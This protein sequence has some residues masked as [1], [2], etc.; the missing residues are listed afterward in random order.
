MGEDGRLGLYCDQCNSPLDMRQHR[1]R[2][3]AKCEK[4][5]KLIKLPGAIIDQWDFFFQSEI[6]PQPPQ[7][8]DPLQF[9]HIIC[10]T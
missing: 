7:D 5:G 8:I 2:E 6:T 1:R 4:C 9:V 3:G 10:P